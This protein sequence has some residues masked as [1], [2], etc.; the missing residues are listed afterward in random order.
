[1][2]AFGKIKEA[3]AESPTLWRPNFNKEF[4]LYTFPSDHSIMDVLTQKY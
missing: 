4:I 2:E 1:M 3:I